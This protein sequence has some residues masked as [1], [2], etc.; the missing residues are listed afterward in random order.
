MRSHDFTLILNDVD[1]MDEDLS[2][3]LYE[4]GCDDGSPYSS[5]G[6]AGIRFHREAESLESAIRS[7]ISYIQK[8]G[9][10]VARLI[11]DDDEL[12]RLTNGMLPSIRD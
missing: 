3:Q 7:A 11:M 4:A 2:N 8:T 1:V 10:T 5:Q 9:L 12:E 6:V